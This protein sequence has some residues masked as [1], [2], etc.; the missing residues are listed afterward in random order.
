MKTLGLA[1][2]GRASR[3]SFFS[4][5]IACSLLT[6]TASAQLFDNLQALSSRLRVGDPHVTATNSIDG[7]KGIAVA[8]LNGDGKPDLAVAN[9]DG[10]VTLFFG[11]G[12]GSFGPATHLQTGV[13]ELRGIVCADFTG[14]GHID[15]A[16]AAPYAGNVYL[17]INQGGG[18][19]AP[20]LTLEM[21]RG[22]RNL[23]A[24]DFDGDGLTD[25]IVAGT[26]NGL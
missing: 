8:D 21:W 18:V 15:V 16:V 6:G 19:F 17:F 14:D 13:E 23:T 20:A 12:D 5:L 2:A 25:L 22:A 10:T 9:T 3:A 1:H 11:V 7:P 26:T 24:G 4:G